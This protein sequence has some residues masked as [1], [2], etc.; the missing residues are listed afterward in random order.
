MKPGPLIAALLILAV[1]L[2]RWHRL[3]RRARILGAAGIL[4]LAVWGSGAIHPPNIETAAYELGA[5]LGP[6]TYALVGLMAFL[7]TGVGV[8]LI[9]PGEV[10]VIVGGVTAGQGHTDLPLLIAL[11]SACA[12]AGDLTS[13]ILGRRLGRD[14]L[15]KHGRALRLTPGRLRQV[16]S[17]LARHGGETILIGRFIGMV[18][19]LAPFVAG[20]S[21]MPAR[22]F[23]P[24]T[25]L[26]AAIWSATFSALG[27]AFWQSFDQAVTLAKQGTLVLAAV[28][29][30]TIAVVVLFRTIRS[31]ERR[32]RLRERARELLAIIHAVRRR[33]TSSR[34]DPR[35]KC[36]RK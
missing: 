10:A 30:T 26:A 34:A 17:F 29:A 21:R 22:R 25:S 15:R 36:C 14:F 3:S 33:I 20:S 13:Y 16:E 12:V 1:L 32:E 19:S 5:T 8:G 28:V 24:A 27:Y 9:A 23:I 7:E 4:G 18:R 35:P 6:Y 11:V 31:R 2:T